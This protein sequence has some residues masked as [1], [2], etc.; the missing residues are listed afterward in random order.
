MYRRPSSLLSKIDVF[1]LN[2][3]QASSKMIGLQG[4]AVVVVTLVAFILTCKNH[5]FWSLWHITLCF[6]HFHFSASFLFFVTKPSVLLS[7]S[8]IRRPVLQRG[9]RLHKTL[10]FYQ[11][12]RPCFAKERSLFKSH[13]IYYSNCTNLN[14]TKAF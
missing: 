10:D 2:L 8:Y 14:L 7:K 3:Q 13:A 11:V 5:Y 12:A 4:E 6:L 1:S 9:A